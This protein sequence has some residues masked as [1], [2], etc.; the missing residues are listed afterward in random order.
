LDHLL[1]NHSVN[2]GKWIL[3]YLFSNL[4][5]AEIG[6]DAIVRQKMMSNMQASTGLRRENAP[7]L[8]QL[9]S[10]PTQGWENGTLDDDSQI[11]PRPVDGSLLSVMTPELSIGVATPYVGGTNLSSPVQTHLP[12]TS[13]EGSDLEKR[14]S[15]QI[16]PRNSTEKQRDYFSTVPSPHSPS[17]SQPKAPSTPGDGSSETTSQAMVDDEKKAVDEE[18]KEKPKNISSLFDKKFR[19]TFPKKLGRTSA[20]TRPV[21]VDEKA[22]ESDRSEEKEKTFED[23]FFGTIQKVRHDYEEH[24]QK[25]P[26]D[27]LPLGIKPSLPHETPVISL[28]PSTTIIVQEDRPDSGG[29]ADLYRG[30]VNSVELDVDLIEKAGPRWLGDLLLLVDLPQLFAYQA[31]TN[32]P[33]TN[34]HQRKSK[35][36][37]LS[38]YLTKTFYPPLLVQTGKL[39]SPKGDLY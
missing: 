27:P 8:L 4:I 11:T 33:R 1:I 39:R 19:M 28:P 36:S 15:R 23:N 7:P 20:E 24:Y 35:K 18:K 38:Y 25:K 2:F 21:A 29:V 9:P 16:Q 3:R 5:E 32:A 14:L 17:D 30:T 26:F 34:C 37:P 6:R 10:L 22:E 13:E 31:R 12:R